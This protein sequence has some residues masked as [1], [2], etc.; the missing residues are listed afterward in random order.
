MA[1]R[2]EFCYP[3]LSHCSKLHDFKGSAT[4]TLPVW[5]GQCDALGVGFEQ[6]EPQDLVAMA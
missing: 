4:G 1:L 5:P 3:S 2:T 6:K